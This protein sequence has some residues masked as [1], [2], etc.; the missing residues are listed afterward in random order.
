MEKKLLKY[1]VFDIFLSSSS[2]DTRLVSFLESLKFVNYLLALMSPDVFG[3]AVPAF[4]EE[5]GSG[6]VCSRSTLP[7]SA[8]DTMKTSSSA[9]SVQRTR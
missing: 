6:I 7:R 8:L 3:I 2:H 1:P 4:A 9:S 5:S